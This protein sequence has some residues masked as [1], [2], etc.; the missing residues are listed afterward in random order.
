[1]QQ[2]IENQQGVRKK[3]NN[4]EQKKPGKDAQAE[5]VADSSSKKVTR[6][7]VTRAGK[8]DDISDARQSGKEVKKLPTRGRSKKGTENGSIAKF[9]KKDNRKAHSSDLTFAQDLAE[10]ADGFEAKATE[11]ATREPYSANQPAEV[12]GGTMR[13]YQLAGLDWLVSLYE[14]GLNGILADE[15]GLGKTVQTISLLAHLRSKGTMGP[16]LV[17]APLSTLSNWVDEFGKWTP[18]IPTLLY[19][20]SPSERAEFRRTRL[21]VKSLK[22]FPVVCTSYEICMNDRK[23]LSQFSWKFVIIVRQSCPISLQTLY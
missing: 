19:H 9:L 4:A 22:E 14:N 18:G 12:T 3:H 17:V 2:K 20:G 6:A 5:G 1:M 13:E 21:S 11:V 7:S 10:A 15:M 8:G 16:F 23:F